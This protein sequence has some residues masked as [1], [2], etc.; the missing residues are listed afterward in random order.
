ML[1]CKAGHNFAT[2][3]LSPDK[4]FEWFSQEEALCKCIL[5]SE[6]DEGKKDYLC[7]KSKHASVKRRGEI[8]PFSHHHAHACAMTK[9][10]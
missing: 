5:S 10:K 4:G 9:K 3:L 2:C 8:N 1:S 7:M 6:S